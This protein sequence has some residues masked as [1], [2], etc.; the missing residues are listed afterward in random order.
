MSTLAM[1]ASAAQDAIEAI[2]K[3]KKVPLLKGPPGVGKSWINRNIAEKYNLKLIDVRMTQLEPPDF[4]G[5]PSIDFETGKS[6]YFP[7]DMFP[8][9]GDPLPDGYSG[10]YIFFDELTS[11]NLDMQACAYKVILDRMIGQNNLHNRCVLAAAGN[12]VNDSAIV[13]EMSSA[14]VSR[15]VHINVRSDFKTFRNVALELG[16]DH[17]IRSFMEFKPNVVNNFD[18][19]KLGLE[20]TYACERTWHFLSDIMKDTPPDSPL[21]LYV[22]AGTVGEGIARE[23][24][25]FCK[26]YHSLPKISEIISNPETIG[27]PIEPGTLY[28]LTGSLAENTTTENVNK[29]MQYIKRMPLDFQVVTLRQIIH[30]NREM[31]HTVPAI[32]DWI[33]TQSVDLFYQRGEQ[34]V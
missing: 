15:F 5:F 9:E 30:Q 6:R 7:M 18:P 26:V 10:W 24:I 1:S 27:I 2:I 31:M 28:A 29:L 34:Y 8:L 23:F 20:D 14:L 11:A 22:Y 19:D 21:A 25:G 4:V 17:R 16:F 33:D 32:A 13:H 12:G 3:A